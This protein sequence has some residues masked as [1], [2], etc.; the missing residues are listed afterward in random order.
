VDVTGSGPVTQTLTVNVGSGVN[1][2]T[3]SLQVRASSGSLTKTANLSL[4]VTPPPDFTLSLN[5]TSL[6]VQQGASGTTQ[7]TIT[8]QNGFAGTV[9]LSLV[10]GSGNPVPGITLAPPS[11]DVTGSGP[12]TQTL[13][14]NV[15]SGVNPGTYS[16]QV[17]AS[18][19]SLTKTANLSLTV[20]PPP[21]FTL[22]LNPTSLT[23]QQGA[24]GTT[25]LTITPQ[26]GFAG[27]VSLSLVDGSGNPV[28]G[29]TL[30]PP[31]VD[32]TGSG[33]VT[34]TLT[35]NVGSGVNPGTYSLQVRASS[36]SLTKTANLSLTV[37]PPPDFTLSLNP[38]S[39]TVQQGA[40]GTTQL[41][42]TPQNG[43]AGTVSLSL[44]DGSGNP[45]PG[46]TLAPPSVD[47]TGSGPVTQTLTVNV[48]S[49]VNPGT[50]SLQ[51]RASSGSLTKTANLSL[52]VTPPPD[53]T[54]SLN[55][56][57]LTVQQGAS[58]TTQLT[59][60]PQNGFAGT[61]SLSLVDGSGNPVPGITLAPPSVD[62]TGSGPVTQT[63]T[64]NVGSGV[65]PGTYSL[66]VRASSGS[67]TKTANLSLTVTPPPD[68]TLS[69]NP[70]SLTVQQGA[71]GT[72]QLTITPQ[73]GFAGTV[74][75]S[76]VDGSGNPVP[77]ITLAPP[78]VDVTGSGPVTQTLTVNVGS[79]VNPGT[80]SLQVRASSGSLTKTANLSLTVTPPPDF[81]LSLN[82]TSLTVQQGASGTT[83]LTI[84]P[85]NGFAG[86]VSLS[87]VDGSGNPVPGITLAPPSV[88][89]TGSG[90]VTQTLTVNVGSGVNPGTYS[91]QVRASS[92]SL[93]KTANLSLTVT[94]PPDFTLSLN[95]TSLTVQQGASGTTQLTITPQN[96]F[97]GTVSLSLVDGSGNPVPGITLAPPSV[98]VT[99]SG[100][101]TQTL[102]V[103]VGSG[104]NPGTYSL[105]VRAS[106]GSLT[107]TANLS[108]TVT[109]AWTLRN[110]GNL[111]FGVTYGNSLFVAVGDYGAIL[112]SPDGETWTAQNLGTDNFFNGVTYEN[113]LFVAVGGDGTILTSPDG[114]TWTAQNSGTS[115]SLLEATYG[116][117]RFVAVGWSGTILTSPDGE[118]WTAQNSPTGYPLFGV[119]YGN[120]RFVAVGGSAPSSPPRTGRPGRRRTRGQA[121]SSSA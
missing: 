103:N 29:I 101:V 102:T 107:K 64:V 105:Q 81:T 68:F 7:L 24:S 98:D 16:L 54:L 95:P 15:G 112:T 32:V 30:A 119:T 104:V 44:V 2:G 93:T 115:E 25:Q 109:A 71:S 120:G 76:L 20:T 57:S 77:G 72:T 35:V 88:D 5:P 78:S 74:S 97:A 42:I 117:G 94:P 62:V 19:G 11:V 9:S 45:V 113:G 46:I 67:L 13:T 121:P 37:T 75:L 28:P 36:G 49:G 91:L 65:N 79:G 14:V 108:L 47:V 52:T 80:Y 60:T 100:P 66:Q 33:P 116:N 114:E 1:P 4:T 39:L 90:P 73:N 3:Y 118:T 84:T 85:Q 111:L 99:G 18:S 87:L 21:D 10:D 82:P 38:T 43:F 110:L 34:Q 50:Y 51:V 8:P 106:S 63:L 70:T 12:V 86:T 23:V 48:G 59:I 53:F 22:S 17:R 96:G 69:L 61:V 92:G 31:S 56:T 55:P 58:G 6:T 27:T 83:Q 26:N 40:S 89:V 41:T